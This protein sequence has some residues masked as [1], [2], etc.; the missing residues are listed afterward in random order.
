MI[1]EHTEDITELWKLYRQGIDYQNSIGIRTDIPKYIDFY[2]GRQWPQ[3]TERTRNLPRPVINIIK[4]IC[5]NKKAGILSSKIRLVYKSDTD[6]AKVEKFNNFAW[7]IEKEMGQSA[8]D[9]SAVEDGVKKGSY[10][11]HYYWDVNAEGKDADKTGA[12]RCELID[13]LNIFFENPCELDEQKQ[14]W[15]IIVTRENVEAVKSKADKDALLD[16]IVADEIENNDYNYKEQDT[17]KLCTVITRYF[18]ENGRVL[19]ERATKKTVVNKPFFVVPI[20][21]DAEN[22]AKDKKKA[23]SKR[24]E[25]RHSELYPIVAGYYEKRDKCIYGLSEIEGLIPNQK[26]INFQI[27]LILLNSQQ[28]ATG[29]Y[30][31]VPNA[32]NGQKITNEPGQL[33]IDYSGTGTGIKK[34]TEQAIHNIPLDIVSTIINLTRSASGSSEVMTGETIGANMSGAAIAYLQAQAKMPV[35]DLRDTFWKVKEK[36][37]KVLAQ[38]YKHFYYEKDFT[39]EEKGENNESKNVQDK[40][41]SSE[42]DSI[43]FDVV[44]EATQGTRSSIASDIYLLDALLKGGNI[45]LE[46]Y[47]DAYPDEAIGNKSQIKEAIKASQQSELAMTRQM[48]A[49]CQAQL[50]KAEAIIASQNDIVGKVDNIVKECQ[51]TKRLLVEVA[52]EEIELATQ[53][54]AEIEAIKQEAQSKVNE[55]NGKLDKQNQYIMGLLGVPR[56]Q[57]EQ[58]RQALQRGELTRKGVAPLSSEETQQNE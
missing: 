15:I 35:D 34:M 32:L 20:K 45:S 19:C 58:I 5:R 6:K 37:G 51:Q 29:K 47:I 17:K 57:A 28:N 7:F 48:L 16:D 26:A 23:V 53:A 50:K 39:H 49:E 42:F 21:E 22:T 40:F 55:A 18:K 11:Y 33:L 3:P 54:N 46:A 27:A 36:Q 25:Q 14:G 31:A 2:E 38:F 4:M 9:K 52:N 12:L 1:K 41:S 10:F 43:D 24:K 30:I 13:P 8:L 56:E 44:V